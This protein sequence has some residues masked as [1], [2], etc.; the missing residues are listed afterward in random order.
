M[1]ECI[2]MHPGGMRASVVELDENS[3]DFDVTNGTNKVV[4][5]LHCYYIIFFSMMLLV[6]L[7][8]VSRAFQSVTGMVT[9]CST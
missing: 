1:H 5:W 7:K 9:M 6:A 4:F 3:T 2:H 8:V